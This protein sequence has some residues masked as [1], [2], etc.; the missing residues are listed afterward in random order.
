MNVSQVILQS[1]LEITPTAQ[2]LPI[3]QSKLADLIRDFTEKLGLDR[4]F[5]IEQIAHQKIS[6]EDLIL[7]QIQASNYHLRIE[8]ISKVAESF[9]QTFRK[10]QANQ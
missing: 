1:N 4:P 6:A 5:S 7:Y 9:M 8:M 10:I 2:K 3:E